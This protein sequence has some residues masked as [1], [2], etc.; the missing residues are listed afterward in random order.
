MDWPTPCQ[1]IYILCIFYRGWVDADAVGRVREARRRQAGRRTAHGDPRRGQRLLER[2]PRGLHLSGAG[3]HGQASR[4][5]S[6]RPQAALRRLALRWRAAAAP[7]HYRE[8]LGD[9]LVL[10][11]GRARRAVLDVVVEDVDL[12]LHAVG[13][14]DP[15][16]VLIGVTAVHAELLAYGQPGRLHALHL[17]YHDGLRR[18]LD[19]HVI[20][21]AAA[22]RGPGLREGQIE[23]AERGQEFHVAGLD[24]HRRHAEEPLVERAALLEIL[25]RHV[26]VNLGCIHIYISIKL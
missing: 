9:R 13:V 24:L 18:H 2:Q 7:L 6:R 12:P 10:D 3:R 26:H 5:R 23:R 17:P 19:A 14:L 16:L 8:A 15:E 21:A 4:D 22:L 25:H 11:I 20:D 1:S